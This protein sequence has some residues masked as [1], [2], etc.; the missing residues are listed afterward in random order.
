MDRKNIYRKPADRKSADQKPA[1]K[2]SDKS[3]K[4]A[5][6]P[7]EVKLEVSKVS[8]V[9]PFADSDML[10]SQERLQE[11]IIWSEILGKPVSKRRKRR[12]LWR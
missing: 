12:E 10:I 5:T 4:P 7:L 8:R 11:A 1:A 2:K 6:K 9:V 3:E